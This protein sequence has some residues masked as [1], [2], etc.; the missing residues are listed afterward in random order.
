MHAFIIPLLR[1]APV[2]RIDR[3]VNDKLFRPCGA[4]WTLGWSV[5]LF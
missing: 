4:P 2:S 1:D 3:H 5:V